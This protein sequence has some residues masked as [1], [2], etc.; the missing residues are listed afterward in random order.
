LDV[1]RAALHTGNAVG[2]PSGDELALYRI[3]RLRTAWQRQESLCPYGG[4]VL[5]R[6]AFPTPF[7]LR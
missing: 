4:T 5:V 3:P 7:S 2:P 6:S 1:Q